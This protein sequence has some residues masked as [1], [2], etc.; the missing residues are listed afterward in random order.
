LTWL[1][2]LLAGIADLAAFYSVVA[3]LFRAQPVIVWVATVGFT[4]VGVGLAHQI[5][6]GFKQRRCAD[7]RASALVWGSVA[8]WVGLGTA[9]FVVRWLNAPLSSALGAGSGFPAAGQPAAPAVDRPLL[10]AI[11]FAVLFAASGL[12]A[13][14]TGFHD[15]NPDATALERSRDMRRVAA[16]RREA[17]LAALTQL[18]AVRAALAEE[19]DKVDEHREMMRRTTEASVYELKNRARLLLALDR[20]PDEVEDI[21]DGAPQPPQAWSQPSGASRP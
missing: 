13:A 1:F 16:S 9:A 21:L 14:F 6:V 7:P 2:V 11:F 17:S 18:R 15:H 8:A 10:A 12:L 20:D 5:G 3:V 4:A 19:L